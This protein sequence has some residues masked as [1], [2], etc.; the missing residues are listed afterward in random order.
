MWHVWEIGEEQTRSWWGRPEEKR[1]RGRWE[2]NI[3]MYLQEMGL[4]TWS[5]LIWLR[6]RRGDGRC[7]GGNEPSGSKKMRRISW[8]A[9][10]LLDFHEGVC[11]VQLVDYVVPNY[12]IVVDYELLVFY[13]FNDAV[14][15]E[16]RVDWNMIVD[17]RLEKMWEGRALI[18]KSTMHAWGKSRKHVGKVSRQIIGIRTPKYEARVVTAVTSS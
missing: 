8:L 7:E 18:Y 12:K 9:E 1:P 2:N 14:S 17:H 3:K 6:I 5:G 16:Y 11:C 10:S 13:L 15:K 4:G